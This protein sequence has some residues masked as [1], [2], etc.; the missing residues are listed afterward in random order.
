MMVLTLYDAADT[1]DHGQ[2]GNTDEHSETGETTDE[3][4]NV[5]Q[6]RTLPEQDTSLSCSSL[7]RE[8]NSASSLV[9]G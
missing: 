1:G 4:T 7:Q 3:E 5:F 2:P 9:C 6:A 8:R